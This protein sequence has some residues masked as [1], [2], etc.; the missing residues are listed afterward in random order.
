MRLSDKVAIV[1]GAGSG[2]GKAT[3]AL[4]AAEGAKVIVVD[5]NKDTGAETAATIGQAGGQSVFCHA[6]VSKHGDVQR[7]VNTTLDHYGKLDVLVNNAAI[8]L[9]AQLVDTTEE[10]WDRIQS[11][12]LKGVFLGCKYAIPAMI[13]N[14]GGSIVNIASILGLV[15]D[16]EWV[17]YCA[18]KGGVIAMTRAAALGYGPQGIRVNCICPGDVETPLR[19]WE[20]QQSSDPERARGEVSSKYAL[21]R[22]ASPEE[23]AK[24]VAFLASSDS[25]FL[26]GSSMVVDGGIT[27]RCY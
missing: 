9:M 11:V 12:N 23:I 3:A 1:T 27:V 20:F 13:R 19:A 4:L 15:G 14:G 6:D 21:R 2:I 18:A 22:L 26:T 10:D 25:S 5:W 24:C 17:A 7:M 8:P 16:P